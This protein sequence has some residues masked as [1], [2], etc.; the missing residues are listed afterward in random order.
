MV[1][2]LIIVAV[3]CLVWWLV[4]TYLPMPAPMKTVITVIFVVALCIFLLRFAGIA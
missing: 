1:H 3:L 2:L 4:T